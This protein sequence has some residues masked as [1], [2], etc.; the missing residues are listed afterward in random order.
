MNLQ[1]QQL[2]A[3]H[4]LMQMMQESKQTKMCLLKT[5]QRCF[6]SWQLQQQRAHCSERFQCG[7]LLRSYCEFPASLI[8][9][10]LAYCYYASRILRLL[11]SYRRGCW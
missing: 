8:A 7:S 5:E 3:G 11:D 10:A 4:C 9:W 1:L 2:A 6:Q